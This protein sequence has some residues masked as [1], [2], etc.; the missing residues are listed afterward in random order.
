[1]KLARYGQP[2][3]EKPALVDQDGKLRDLS[4]V[5]ADITPATL[6]EASLAKLRALDVASLPLVE[7]TPR[8][9]CPVNGVGKFLAIGLNYS[10]HAAETGQPVPKEPVVFTKAISCIQGPNDPIMLPRG[11]E[12]TDWE[13]ELGIVIGSV[14][15][16]VEREQALQHVAGYV[17][18]NDVSERHFQLERTPQWD[19]GK[20]CDTFGP[21]G[22]WLVTRDEVPNV[23][24]L[25]MWLEVNG[26]R[27][28]NGSTSTMIFDVAEIVSHL[29]QFMTLMP[30]DV[31]T[32]G[33][34]PGV[35]MGMKPPQFL[36]AGDVVKLGIEGLGEQQQ[37][38][39]PFK[40]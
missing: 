18:I 9:G 4:G 27:V 15:R 13:V 12:K 23:Q 37:T 8:H 1:M 22:P 35:G 3:S 40:L 32:T 19:K 7:G 36:R 26:K 33:T 34:P 28:Q 21:I 17:T 14:T 5:I 16:Y 25:S 30:G 24:A 38:V 39:V 6:D 11:S 20:G 29:S 2:G 10:D 31:I